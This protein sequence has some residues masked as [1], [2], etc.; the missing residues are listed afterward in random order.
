MASVCSSW[1]S[2]ALR[3]G[4]T[5]VCRKKVCVCVRDAGGTSERQRVYIHI[6]TFH[7][8][9]PFKPSPH[10]SQRQCSTTKAQRRIHT[11]GPQGL[12][13]RP[14]P[15]P[16]KPFCPCP[17][18]TPFSFFFAYFCK[19]W[20]GR[21]TLIFG[22]SRTLDETSPGRRRPFPRGGGGSMFLLPAGE[23]HT[24]HTHTHHGRTK[25]KSP[26][27]PG[28]PSG[29]DQANHKPVGVPR[30]E[31]GPTSVD[32]GRRGRVSS[33]VHKTSQQKGTKRKGKEKKTKTKRSWGGGKKRRSDSDGDS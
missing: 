4:K 8:G 12:P 1:R 27:A 15:K 10:H 19:R 25:T 6:P 14:P 29:F 22:G 26:W 2:G 7:S 9:P 33:M 24:G 21:P 32:W 20:K 23:P 31:G 16:P 5:V 28:E 30:G 17:S 3:T 11:A 18:D 13:P